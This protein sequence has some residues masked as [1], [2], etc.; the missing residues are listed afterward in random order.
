[1]KRFLTILILLF[2]LQTFGQVVDNFSDGD[3]TSNPVWTPDLPTNWVV[4]S[5]KLQSNS[6]TLNSSFSI[7]TPSAKATNAQWEFFVNLPFNTSGLNYVDIFL[8][9]NL[10]TLT[11]TSNNGYFVRIGGALDEISLYKLTAGVTSTLINGADGITNFSN[12]TLR[13]KVIRN[14]ANLWTLERDANGGT[15]Y[16][17]EGTVTDNTFTTSNFFGIRVAQSTATFIQKHFFDDFY[18]GNIIPDTSAPTLQSVQSISVNDFVLA[19]NEKL[20]PTSANDFN[21]F[22]VNNSIGK[23]TSSVLQTNLKS[24]KLTFA[25]SFVNGLQNQISVSGVKDLA[26]NAMTLSSLPFL[27]FVAEPAAYGDLVINEL[28]PDPSPQIGLPAVEFVELFNKSTKPFDLSGWK[29]SDPSSFGLLPSLILLPGEFV[30]VT[31]SA[32]VSSFTGKVVGLTSFPTLNNSGDAIKLSDPTGLKIDSVNYHLVWYQDDDKAAGGWTIERLNPLIDTNEETNWLASE[33]LSGGTPGRQNSVFGRN[34]DSKPPQLLSISVANQKELLLQ[35]NEAVLSTAT[36]ISHYSAPDLVIESGIISSDALSVRLIYSTPFVNGLDYSLTIAGIQDLAT[37]T[38]AVTQKTFRYFVSTPAKAKDILINEIMADPSPPVLLFDAEY[39]ELFNNTDHPFDLS[40]WKLGDATSLVALPS[41]ILMPHEYLILNSTA[42]TSNFATLGKS[43]GVVGFPSINNTGE[44]IF[45]KDA[46]GLTI[47]SVL[48]SSTWYESE[49]KKDGGWSLERL[50]PLVSSNEPTNWLA[51]ENTNGGSPGK[52]NS[53]FGKN[54]DSKSPQLLKLTLISDKELK[55]EFNEAVSANAND[56]THY[57]VNN[58]LNLVSSQIFPDGFS[59]QLTFATPC[60][61]GLDYEIIIS[62]IKDLAENVI[63]T[64]TK[65]FRYFVPVGALHKDVIISEI[66]ADPTPTVQLPEGEYI[67]IFNRTS[68]PFDLNKWTL[69]DEKTSAALPSHIIFPNEYLILTSTSNA[70][71]FSGF[72]KAIGVTNF[73]SINNA[74]KSI[75][76]KDATGAVMDFVKFSID[77]YRDDEK[78]DGGFSLEIIDVENI[79]GEENNWLA[80]D[81][82]KG[83]TP[84]KQNSIFAN[85]PDLTGP[86]LVSLSIANSREIILVFD[87]KL[88]ENVS[89]SRLVLE[90]NVG[91]ESAT[92]TDISLRNLRLV[93]QEPLVVG[94][95]YQLQIENLSDCNGNVIQGDFNRLPFALPEAAESGDLLVN[96]ILSDPRPEGVDFIEIYNRSQK[97]INLKNWSLGNLEEGEAVNMKHITE[98]D[99]IIPPSTY[100]VFTKDQKILKDQY[101]QGQENN[102]FKTDLPSL[103]DD[104]GSIALVNDEQLIIDSVTYNKDFHSPLLRDSEGISLERIS[105]E[106]IGTS[107]WKSATSFAGFATP[108]FVNSNA[109]PENQSEEDAILVEPEIIS[110]AGVNEFAQIKYQFEESGYV[111]NVKVY[112]QQGHPIKEITNNETLGFEGFLRWDGDTEEGQKARTGYYSVW[113]EIFDLLGNVK[114]YRKRLVVFNQAP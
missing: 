57:V 101:P 54:P 96:E 33:D 27:Y 11:S 51:S 46:N 23:P 110:F 65:S 40:G 62:G 103:P 52:Q 67:E 95:L 73:Q 75:V 64:T 90:P 16:F 107:N 91:V 15:D 106:A 88:D 10:T 72:G 66:M 24:V 105:F 58:N 63:S 81:D 9:S 47:D 55:L 71:K 44:P 85:K 49:L 5:E 26:G 78:S 17:L 29:L 113:C 86:K 87:E 12:N 61:N 94:V 79:C 100:L 38:M 30:T 80:S 50:N 102:F 59:I 48:F 8:T 3:F 32:A 31:S 14:A 93:F 20:D 4:L 41:K 92:F 70:S 114:V 74:G 13:I 84:G 97:Y 21:N 89:S 35:F 112:D 82:E 7:T 104:E 60:V 45:I 83:G 39:I 6:A 1:M 19:F 36:D 43:L 76:L 25:S 18:V 22:L 2:S 77:W 109:R 99:F 28:F 34:P 68:N 111:A 98:H 56:I 69:S 42:N 108:G 37:N 53:V